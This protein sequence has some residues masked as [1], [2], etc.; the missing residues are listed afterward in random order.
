MQGVQITEQV[1]NPHRYIHFTATA[2]L[3]TGCVAVLTIM[4]GRQAPPGSHPVFKIQRPYNT[5]DINAMG[6]GPAACRLMTE[7]AAAGLF[8]DSYDLLLFHDIPSLVSKKCNAIIYHLRA[9]PGNGK[10]IPC[11]PSGMQ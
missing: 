11:L 8:F 10:G 5:A 3:Y 9:G 1:F 4:N 6:T 7:Q 2:G